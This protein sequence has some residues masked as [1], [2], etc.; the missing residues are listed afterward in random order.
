MAMAEASGFLIDD[1]TT[2]ARLSGMMGKITPFCQIDHHGKVHLTREGRRRS[3]K[4]RIR[5]VVSAR[6]IG[7][8]LD[9]GIASQVSVSDLATQT[10]LPRAQVSARIA[11]LS[12]EGFVVS[13]AR[14]VFHAIGV[15]IEEFLDELTVV[16]V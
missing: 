8:R 12:R 5:L 14:G 11:E 16:Q 4:E 6:F 13:P 7:A 3:A 1:E 10:G 9:D 15:R 2:T